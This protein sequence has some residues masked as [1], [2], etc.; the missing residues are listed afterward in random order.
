MKVF[1]LIEDSYVTVK[2]SGDITI[3]FPTQIWL[4]FHDD[5][6]KA[7]PCLMKSF[8]LCGWTLRCSSAAKTVRVHLH[9][10]YTYSVNIMWYMYDEYVISTCQNRAAFTLLCGKKLATTWEN[11]NIFNNHN[12]HNIVIKLSLWIYRIDVPKELILTNM[13]ER[14]LERTFF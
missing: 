7:L 9:H 11:I 4:Y 2:L 12:H 6:N 10:Y 13:L 1:T 14:K 5:S 3:I 8:C